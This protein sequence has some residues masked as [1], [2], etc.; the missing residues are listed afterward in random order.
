MK[1]YTNYGI[2]FLV[3]KMFIDT[4]CHLSKEDYSNID[5]VVSNM[6]NNI[7]I[8]SG[9]DDKTN[10][11]VIE[12]INKY[13]NV[14][15]MVGIH[16]SEIN[17]IDENTFIN[18]EKYLVNPKIVGVGEIG[19]DYHYPDIN[20]ENQKEI[21]EK[22]IDIAKKYNKTIIIHSRDSYQDTYNILN[23]YQDGSL[24]I[25]MHCYSYSLDSAKEL[26]KLNCKFGIGGV[27]TFKN[28]K[29]LIEVVEYLDNNDILLETDSPY[30]TPEPFRGQKNE[31]KNA[32]YVAKKIADIKQIPL[33]NLLN[34]TTQ[35]A[36]HQFDLDINL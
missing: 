34:I 23:K 25:V 22:Q 20:K 15:G 28:A 19:L 5:E 26:Q 12:Y 3:I 14:Y 11:E 10:K 13:S 18:L 24:N 36:M 27:I 31:P 8:I 17:S 30:L 7:M 16:P 21:F 9:V 2:F 4:H 32:I 35:T 1:K 33:E 29:K 6:E